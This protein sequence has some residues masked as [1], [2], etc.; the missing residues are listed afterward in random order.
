MGLKHATTE[1]VTRESLKTETK[2]LAAQLKL[3]ARSFG[4]IYTTSDQRFFF[5]L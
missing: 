3:R 5:F 1:S 2:R 4:G